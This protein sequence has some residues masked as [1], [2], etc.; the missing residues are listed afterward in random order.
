MFDSTLRPSRFEGFTHSYA[1]LRFPG[2]AGLCD[3]QDSHDI[4]VPSGES[5]ICPLL[6]DSQGYAQNRTTEGRQ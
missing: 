3:S 2:F 4:P 5:G 1:V 6:A